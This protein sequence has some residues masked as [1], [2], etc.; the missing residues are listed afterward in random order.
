VYK[1]NILVVWITKIS[2]TKSLPKGVTG[3]PLRDANPFAVSM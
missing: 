3:I 2:F 1:T